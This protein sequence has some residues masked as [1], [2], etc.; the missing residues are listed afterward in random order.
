MGFLSLLKRPTLWVSGQ[1]QLVQLYSE[2]WCLL[3]KYGDQVE[4]QV[5][6]EVNTFYHFPSRVREYSQ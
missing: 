2:D 3:K 4:T 5:E 1:S 6:Q